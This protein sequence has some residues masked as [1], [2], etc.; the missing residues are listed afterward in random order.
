MAN[1]SDRGMRAVVVGAG[2][3]GLSAAH[4]LRAQGF[5]VVVLEQARELVEI[6]AGINLAPNATRVLRRYGVLDSLRRDGVVPEETVYRRWSDGK[7]I[8]R[9]RIGHDVERVMGAPLFTLHRADLQRALV[10][11]LPEGVV[12]LGVPVV[13]VDQD[14]DTVTATLESGERVQGDVLI[15]ADGVRS[16]LRARLVDDGDALYSGFAVYRTVLSRDDDLAGIDLDPPYCNW[17]GPGKHLV[18]YWISRG[19]LLNVVAVF[20]APQSEDSWLAE[21]DPE[22]LVAAFDDWNGDVTRLLVR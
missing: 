7:V 5:D 22:E 18:H 20:R 11:P 4:S 6:G 17:L 2:I 3:A 21:A 16:R 14:A 8:A 13:D 19:E 10:E 1:G 15:V 9:R 12:R